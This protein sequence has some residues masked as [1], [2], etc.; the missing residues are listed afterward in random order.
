MKLITYLHPVHRWRMSE[1][2]PLYGFLVGTWTTLPYLK[3]SVSVFKGL[4][5]NAT[6]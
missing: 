2:T 5:Q 6:V 1:A 4:L 3:L